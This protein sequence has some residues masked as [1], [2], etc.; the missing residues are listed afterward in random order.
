MGAE[1]I[2]EAGIITP[3]GDI[4]TANT[5]QDE[6]I[7]WAIRSGGGGTLVLFRV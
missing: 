1:N 6:G 4:L 5:C 3:N 7:F 2:L